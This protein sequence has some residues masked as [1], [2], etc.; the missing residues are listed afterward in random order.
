MSYLRSGVDP[1]TGQYTLSVDLPDIN[2][3]NL[4][5]PG[6]PLDLAFSPLNRSDSGYGKGWDLKLSQFASRTNIITLSSGETFAVTEERQDEFGNTRLIMKEQK[7]ES[8]RLY[9]DA[10]DRVRVVHR[11]GLVE[12]LAPKGTLGVAM[13]V[14][15]Y[16][17]QG[18]GL[19]L[20][21][22]DFEGYPRLEWVRGDDQEPLLHIDRPQGGNVI[23]VL[24][25]PDGIG[26][27][28]A[29]FVMRLGTGNLVDRIS[30]PTDPDLEKRASWR[31]EYLLKDGQHCI[32]VLQ[33]PTGG[34]EE[35]F[36]TDGGHKI[37][38]G[39][40]LSTLPRVNQH[41]I[42]PGFG[43]PD[44]DVRYTYPNDP[45]NPVEHN[46]LGY[47]LTID[48]GKNAGQ[49]ALYQYIGE[50][51]YGSVEAIY[52]ADKPVRSIERRFNQFHLQT[53]EKTTQGNNI[54]EVISG[55]ELK[56]VEFGQQVS[57]FQLPRSTTRRWWVKGAGGNPYTQVETFDYDVQ[58]NIKTHVKF[59][60]ITE[61]ND[62]YPAG[63]DEGHPQDKSGFIRHLK[64]STLTPASGHAG[65]AAEV[66]RRYVYVTLPSL[67]DG[68]EPSFV[69]DSETLEE[70]AAKPVTWQSIKYDYYRDAAKQWQYGRMLSQVLTIDTF[71]TTSTYQY[72]LQTH[73]PK[74]QPHLISRHAGE[75]VLQTVET[76]TG[77]DGEQ[78]VITSEHSVLHDLPLLSRDDNDVEI[79]YEYDV[80]RRTTLETVAPGQP[81]EASRRYEYTLCAKQGEQASQTT[82]DVKSVQTLTLVDGLNRPIKERRQDQD[83]L[84]EKG[85][86]ELHDT[87]EA[88]YDHLGNLVSETEIDWLDKKVLKLTTTFEYDDWGE[89]LSQ[90]GPDGVASFTQTDY[91]DNA[92][93][94]GKAITAWRMA[95][96]KAQTGR[97]VTCIDAF[98]NPVRV[99]RF[100]LKDQAVSLEV[101][102]YDGLGRSAKESVG[103]ESGK[104]RVNEYQYDVFD[105]L[106]TH[107]VGDQN[108]VVR[109]YAKHSEKDLPTSIKVAGIELGT[110]TFDGLGRLESATTGGRLQKY[111]Y[112]PGQ[113]QPSRVYKY[114][115]DLEAYDVIRYEYQPALGDEPTRRYLDN[116]GANGERAAE[117]GDAGYEYDLQKAW[118]VEHT[119]QGQKVNRTYFS[120]GEVQ[121][122]TR[123]F[124]SSAEP[125]E[126]TY[127]YSLRSRQERYTDV[128]KQVQF[129]AYDKFGRLE[130]TTLG[131]L[132]TSFTYDEFGRTHTFTTW[133]GPAGNEATRSLVTTL[134]YDEFERE[135][136]R[137]F[138]FGDVKQT[139]EQWY[140]D[141]DGLKQRT[142]KE[143]GQVLRDEHYQ[144]DLR[145][146]L[147]LYTCKG[148]DDQTMPVQPPEDP[149]GNH[150]H[151]QVFTFDAL[152]NIKTLVTTD[153]A[154]KIHRTMYDF[155][156][157][158]P[159]QLSSFKHFPAGGTPI[160]VKLDYDDYGNMIKDEA[161]RTLV[162]D[163]LNRLV[164]VDDGTQQ[165]AYGYDA[166]DVL[167]NTSS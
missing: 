49:D 134:E 113:V 21:Y 9:R 160:E 141:F 61:V 159:A 36:Y 22:A 167:T 85:D 35:L 122:E 28:L 46:F 106:T 126:M 41:L 118:L 84:L 115:K 97:T 123:A 86:S 132:V 164:S 162:Y 12:I 47:G 29:E 165:Q 129:Y 149:W 111:E 142:L 87:F 155:K 81:Y 130:K 52:Q 74:G 10:G 72:T 127:H 57:T 11:S 79:R 152:D 19:T 121:T 23:K 20:E 51:S 7:L 102:L 38:S 39:G 73:V 91:V 103:I 150:I 93:H 45:E 70:T 158:D 55:Y 138:D 140:N 120:T 67:K 82:F 34:V 27:S 43:Q 60:G 3:N 16:T 65:K 30:L 89:Q 68:V 80:L 131:D 136:C 4:Q 145:G 104:I 2:A 32:K 1:R 59:S 105:R 13:P 147:D 33:T 92:N 95:P 62:W 96:N 83:N 154:N 37:P 75:V 156:N 64:S 18:H 107:T 78:K 114:R 76:L 31:I 69:L 110:Q 163:A 6:L 44:R 66:V 151:K 143:E 88:S 137:T 26:G 63:Q 144:Y 25:Y 71:K 8:F 166:K 14:E 42:K 128:L 40:G 99:E 24:A 17:S 119:A 148:V 53:L 100:D 5:G 133:D 56:S 58:G 125:Y 116:E 101:K 90:T 77:H 117:I 15:V 109:A 157:A 146:R 54:V 139:L 124:D 48:W 98:D 112:I 108:K 50:Y 135:K 161:G 94:T 153:L